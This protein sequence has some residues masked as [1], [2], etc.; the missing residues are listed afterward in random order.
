MFFLKKNNQLIIYSIQDLKPQMKIQIEGLTASWKFDI[1]DELK[2]SC[3]IPIQNKLSLLNQVDLGLNSQVEENGNDNQ[4]S[5]VTHPLLPSC[6][7]VGIGD[8]SSN[9]N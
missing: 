9:I 7:H 2:N 8:T 4:Q 6:Q 3:L 5:K 1:R